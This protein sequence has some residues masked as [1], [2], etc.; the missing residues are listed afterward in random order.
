MSHRYVRKPLVVRVLINTLPYY[1]KG[2]GLRTYTGNLLNA[3]HESNIDMEWQVML[4]LKDM[5]RLGLASDRRFAPALLAE[6]MSF[7]LL[8][9][10]RFIRRNALDH[11][12]IPQISAKRVDLVHFLDSYG[13]L[14]PPSKLP[15]IVTVHDLMPLAS[16]TY[17]SR[18]VTRYLAGLMRRTIPRAHSVIAVSS[19]TAQSVTA[20]T[21]MPAHKVYVAP[22]GVNDSF[23]PYA[24][25]EVKGVLMKYGL[26]TPYLITVGTIEP[27]K[28]IARLVR[29]FT[30]A[31]QEH[32]LPHHLVIAGKFGWKYDDVLHAIDEAN[33]GPA[34]KVLGYVPQDHLVRMISAATALVFPSLEEGFGLPIIE[35]MACGTPVIVGRNSPI[36]DLV[37]GAVRFIEPSDEDEMATAI[38]EICADASKRERLT[39]IGLS[40]ARQF[41]WSTLASTVADIYTKALTLS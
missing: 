1:G 36:A 22:S 20:L 2:E 29:A 23:R 17:H 13:P 19:G 26:S 18:W 5:E 34:I 7:P 25:D 40:R 8:P 37:A 16:A 15:V 30:R 9:G 27:R 10:I 41:K 21:G 39:Q 24:Y 28:N 14:I 35:G 3:F 4:S 6:W 32:V 12:A 11:V 31:K 33:L 38:S